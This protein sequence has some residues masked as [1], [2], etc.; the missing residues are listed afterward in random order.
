MVE[1]ALYI[2]SWVLRHRAAFLTENRPQKGHLVASSVH[3]RVNVSRL[4]IQ[5]VH[6]YAPCG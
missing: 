4:E 1:T 3:R 5:A 2:S 6:G